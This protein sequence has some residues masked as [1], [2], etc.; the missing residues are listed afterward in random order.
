M[1]RVP[2]S[3]RIFFGVAAAATVEV[4]ETRRVRRAGAGAAS[5]EAKGRR[6]SQGEQKIGV[7]AG[8]GRNG[9]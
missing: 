6:G 5:W 3:M 7:G 2:P 4:A 1:K 9:G 8:G